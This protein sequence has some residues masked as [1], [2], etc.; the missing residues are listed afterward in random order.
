MKT[1]LYFSVQPWPLI[2]EQYSDWI[3]FAT[4]FAVRVALS[5]AGIKHPSG[6]AADNC[7]DGD[8]DPEPVLELS[9]DSRE[10]A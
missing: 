4:I 5:S 2:H 9:S 7:D 1:I 10:V 8:P 3:Q 6:D